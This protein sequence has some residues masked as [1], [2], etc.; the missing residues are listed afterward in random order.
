M[1]LIKVVLFFKNLF[2]SITPVLFFLIS[3]SKI[4][5]QQNSVNTKPKPLGA[6]MLNIISTNVS[7]ESYAVNFV[8]L[9]GVYKILYNGSI[10]IAPSGGTAPYTFVL[11][12]PYALQQTNGYFT[13]LAP[14]T[15]NFQITDANGLMADTT[16]IITSLY[17]QPSVSGTDVA[18]PTSCTSANISFV[19]NG[20]GGTLPYMYSIDGGA[21]FT[22]NDTFSNLTIGYYPFLLLKDANGFLALTGF[23][24][25]LDFTCC[26]PFAIITDLTNGSSCSGNTGSISVSS[27]GGTPPVR[28]SADGLNYF[29]GTVK[30]INNQDS[31]YV[32]VFTNLAPG[33]HH[34][35]A[36]DKNNND[37]ICA[38]PVLQLC[39]PI[40]TAAGI[41]TNCGES[42]GSITVK[43]N[44]GAAPYVYTLDGINFQPNNV[45]NNLASGNYTVSVK[46]ANGIAGSVNVVVK[47]NCPVVSVT[48]SVATCGNNN[49]TITATGSGGTAPYQFSINGINFQANNV[50]NNLA[51]GNY[52]V[53]IKDAGNFTATT[54][55]IINNNCLQLLPA[56]INASCNNNNGS[57]TS[58]ASDGTAPYQYSID[59]INFQTNNVFDNLAAGNYTITVKDASDIFATANATI[60]NLP[61]PIIN[62]A[63]TQASCSNTNGSIN[64]SATGGTSPLQFSINNGN[65]FQSA[66]IFNNLDSGQYI[67]LI[68]DSNGCMVHDTVQLT[69]L[70]APILFFGNDTTLCNGQTLLLNA[71][72]NNGT[73]IW[74]DSSTQPTFTVNTAGI[75]SVNIFA[76]GCNVS[77]SITVSYITKPVINIGKDT[78]LCIPESL[79]LDASYPQSTYSWQD[80]SV[81]PQFNVTRAGRYAVDVRNIC[82][83]TKDSID[84]TYE[85]CSCRFYVPSA[86]SP[87]NDGKNDLFIP[88]YQ[89][90]F[91]NYEMKIFN[92]LG[93]LVFNSSNAANGWDGNFKNRQQPTGSYVW[94][95][96]YTDNL[97]S[98][99][100]RKTG[101]VVLVR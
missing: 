22:S 86:F 56:V 6:I 80:G 17:P 81:Q 48:A 87:N 53:T 21:T 72:N 42:N 24:N 4:Y 13:N 84:I 2:F 50:F 69:A 88:K 23:T 76:N 90:P 51:S 31:Q 43:A 83:D 40:I 26:C 64:I 9:T 61:P 85:N 99:L 52:T 49:G 74:Q 39:S 18:Y 19:M 60:T 71:A 94:E 16:I 44:N 29:P 41:N 11:T 73:Y 46:D 75:Y 66:N 63:V 96:N 65:T 93:Q 91:S 79:L 45:F 57:I 68:K 67:A 34:F 38:A 5:C 28:F 20:S 36:K 1:V 98:R 58:T 95:L 25:T 33:L 101:T 10:S 77:K 35:Y 100:I 55:V 27:Q 70:P 37:A 32:Y 89:C 15:Y 3:F 62:V 82:G 8:G 59:G 14:G 92:R 12:S 54:A 78:S 47:D 30:Y 7:Y 97:T